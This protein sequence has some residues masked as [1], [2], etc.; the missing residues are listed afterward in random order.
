MLTPGADIKTTMILKNTPDLWRQ[1]HF[2]LEL[3]DLCSVPNKGLTGLMSFINSNL[4]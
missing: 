1:N 3:D 4:I 2:R